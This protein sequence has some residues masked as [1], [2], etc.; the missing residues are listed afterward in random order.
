MN[1]KQ[2]TNTFFQDKPSS[3]KMLKPAGILLLPLLLSCLISVIICGD[4]DDDDMDLII[5]PTGQLVF[6][7]GGGKKGKGGSTIVLARRKRSIRSEVFRVPTGL[8]LV[9]LLLRAD[10]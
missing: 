1:K 3:L 2:L 4:K 8:P 7:E 9:P 5:G 10:V 6:K